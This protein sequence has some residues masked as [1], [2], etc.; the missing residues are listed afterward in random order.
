MNFLAA[1]GNKHKTAEFSRILLPLGI[2]IL[3]PVDLG[4]DL[5][6]VPETGAT[7]EEN[8]LIKAENGAK[9]SGL[10]CIADDS[11]LEVPALGG[12]PGVYSARYGGEGLSDTERNALLLSELENITDIKER[13]ARFVCV[14]CCF[15]PDGNYFFA[16]GE[17]KGHIGFEP[18]GENGFGYDPVFYV[19]KKSFAELSPDE[20]DALSH[21]GKAL[22]KLS[23]ILIPDP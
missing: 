8:A 6:D 22:K 15:C 7:F 9:I 19:G 2:N 12:R 14:I 21:R 17:C 1:T 18:K 16:E 23:D 5:G 3:S 20:K 11:G 10:P 4:I 13:E